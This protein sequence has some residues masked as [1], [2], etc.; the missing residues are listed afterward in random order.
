MLSLRLFIPNIETYS[1][2][3]LLWFSNYH[4]IYILSGYV[5]FLISEHSSLPTVNRFKIN[6][7]LNN[8]YYSHLG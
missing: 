2:L 5:L 1:T 6:N 4:I 7:K 3:I 8:N